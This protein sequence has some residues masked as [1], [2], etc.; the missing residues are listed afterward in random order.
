H[1]D[2]YAFEF[3]CHYLPSYSVLWRPFT[4]ADPIDWRGGLF[5]AY[6][7][8]VFLYLATPPLRRI[9]QTLYRQLRTPI[10]QVGAH[11][12]G[13]GAAVLSGICSII[14]SWLAV[15]PRAGPPH[16]GAPRRLSRRGTDGQEPPA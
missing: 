4:V 5:I 9:A 14:C 12:P 10:R 7:A 3:Y 2:H 6:A 15:V 1:R 13:P 8:A 11:G 16:G